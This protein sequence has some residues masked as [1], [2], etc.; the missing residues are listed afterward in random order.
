MAT[1]PQDDWKVP[2]RDARNDVKTEWVMRMIKDGDSYLQAQRWYRDL[3]RAIDIISSDSNKQPIPRL[4]HVQYNKAKRI[5]RERVSALSAFRSPPEFESEYKKE[6]HDVSILN[7]LMNAWWY[8]TMADR[9]IRTAEQW[10]EI[11]SLGW[12]WPV[13]T[14]DY[15]LYGQSDIE[16]KILGP[17]DVRPIQMGQEHDI[18]KAYAV[19]ATLEMPIARAQALFP[20]FADQLVAN[21]DRA[22]WLA[23]TARA[24]KKYASPAL[25]LANTQRQEDEPVFPTIDIHYCYVHDTGINL[26]GQDIAM[27]EPDTSWQYVVPSLGSDIK[28]GAFDT[29]GHELMRKATD[30]DSMLYPLGRLMIVPGNNKDLV[31]YDDTAPDWHGL[32]PFVPITNDDWPFMFGG[33]S[34]I[35]DIWSLQY[36]IEKDI[37]AMDDQVE[38]KLDPPLLY[39]KNQIAK[40]DAERLTLRKSKVRVGYDPMGGEP[41]KSALG[42]NSQDVPAWVPEQTKAKNAMMDYLAGTKDMEALVKAKSSGA[43]GLEK[44]MEA[45]GPVI[46]DM[47][48]N[49]EKSIRD[50]AEMLK[51]MFFQWYKADRRLKILG[52]DGLTKEDF[53]YKSGDMIP[54]P[55]PGEPRLSYIQRARMHMSKFYANVLPGSLHKIAQMQQQ[56]LY[57]QIKLRNI[58]PVDWWTL[59]KIF[60]I[61][62]FGSMPV[63]CNTVLDRWKA[64]VMLEKEMAGELGLGGQPAGQPP[65]GNH[66]PQQKN[67]PNGKPPIT[68]FSR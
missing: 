46:S 63:N 34:A 45:M 5:I 3:D 35:H 60:N 44:F 10:A 16:L 36:S 9:Q 11:G 52:E 15:P 2:P 55:N 18:Q 66:P 61:P 1:K 8:R 64:Q 21:R 7:K 49:Q 41:I 33:F 32:F 17:R 43:D 58:V 28:T 37:R 4:S 26:S 59:A 68:Q 12:I 31:L 54:E 19:I 47:T 22:S 14:K 56:L 42:A 62:N 51:S 38:V 40:A 30:E 23:R 29:E 25:N 24:I 67:R 48:R 50:L 27:G 65:K 6:E 13:W 39:D 57:M 53:E 20:E